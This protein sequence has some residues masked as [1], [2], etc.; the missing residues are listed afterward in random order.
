MKTRVISSFHEF[1][2]KVAYLPFKALYRGESKEYSSLLPK[3]ARARTTSQGKNIVEKQCIDLFEL[4]GAPYLPISHNAWRLLAIAQHHGL[5]TR[6]L[7]WTYNPAV[8]LYFAVCNHI[9]EDG[10]IYILHHSKTVDI[11]RYPDPYKI[12]EVLIYYA[13]RESQRI[14]AQDGVFTVHPHPFVDARKLL[15]TKYRIPSKLKKEFI[16]RLD[17]MGFSKCTL[18]PGLD[19]LSEWISD[20]KGYNT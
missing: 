7:D 8:A 5:P 1:C 20:I 6:L 12:K 18:F 17:T 4:H 15:H 10:Y 14:I 3:V 9:E 2:D 13:H 11:C 19:S 16:L